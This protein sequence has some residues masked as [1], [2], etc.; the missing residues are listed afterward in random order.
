MLDVFTWFYQMSRIAEAIK[1]KF[2]RVSSSSS[3][4][5]CECAYQ[6]LLCHFCDWEIAVSARLPGINV[7]DRKEVSERRVI[8][9]IA[10]GRVFPRHRYKRAVP[11]YGESLCSIS[12]TYPFPLPFTYLANPIL[13]FRDGG[14]AGIR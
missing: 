9:M 6:A 5:S 10:R 3:K 1:L 4:I 12:S 14:K 13:L 11:F 2:W 8:R 7:V